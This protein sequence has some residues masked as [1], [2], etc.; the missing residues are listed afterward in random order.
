[1]RF[2][3]AAGAEPIPDPERA[4][5]LTGEHRRIIADQ[6]ASGAVNWREAKPRIRLAQTVPAIVPVAR[7]NTASRANGRQRDQSTK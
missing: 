1:M 7:Q 5:L 3:H 2:A 4:E 6:V